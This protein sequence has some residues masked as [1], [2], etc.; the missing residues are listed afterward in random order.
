MSDHIHAIAR[1]RALIEGGFQGRRN[2]T[3]ADDQSWSQHWWKSRMGRQGVARLRSYIGAVR[4]LEQ[5]E[6][7]VT[8]CADC[9]A[10][11]FVCGDEDHRRRGLRA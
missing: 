11:V 10:S 6:T 4:V 3:W 2:A 5:S 7:K 1:L 8:G 9:P